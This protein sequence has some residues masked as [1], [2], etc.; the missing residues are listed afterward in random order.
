MSRIVFTADAF[1]LMGDASAGSVGSWSLEVIS[2]GAG[3]FAITPRARVQVETAP[4]EGAASPLDGTAPALAYYSQT[5]RALF[6]G[7]TTPIVSDGLYL[8]PVDGALAG[9]SIDITGDKT[10]TLAWR[11]VQG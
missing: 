9:L 2:T 8:I 1:L 11:P 7:S 4:S 6:D 3:S 10:L 5:T